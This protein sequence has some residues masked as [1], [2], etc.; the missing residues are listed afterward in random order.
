ME[1]LALLVVAG[2]AALIPPVRQRVWDVT[3]VTGQAG[4]NIGRAGVGVAGAMFSG[5]T[6]IATTAIQGKRPQ[7]AEVTAVA[8]T[9]ARRK[10][11]ATTA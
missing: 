11:A 9:N 1:K 6:G 10:A 3:Q 5:V 2:A 8:A 4:V 7:P